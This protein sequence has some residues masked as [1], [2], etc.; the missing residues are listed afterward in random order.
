MNVC[1]ILFPDD[2]DDDEARCTEQ[3]KEKITELLVG[4]DI[5]YF[6]LYFRRGI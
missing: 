6:P 5:L 2:D 4:F 1:I 3:E